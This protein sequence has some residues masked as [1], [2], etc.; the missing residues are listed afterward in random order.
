METVALRAWEPDDVDAV[1][2]SIDDDILHWI[3][4]IPRPYT[5][6]HAVAFVA[7]PPDDH[8]RAVLYGDAVVGSIGMRISASATGHVGYWCAAR[9]RGR[10][11]MTTALRAFCAE[12]FATLA[13]QRL[14]LIADP[15]NVAS[16][17]LAERVGFRRE[18]VLRSHLQHPDGRRRDSVMYAVLPGELA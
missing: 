17:R 10:G 14:E 11:V 4:V 18:G 6:E 5:R 7:H 1:L 12:A 13:M 3:P 16:Q 9:A 15:D 2:S 8:S